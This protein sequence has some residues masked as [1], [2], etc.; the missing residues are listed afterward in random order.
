MNVI[1]KKSLRDLLLSKKADVAG[2]IPNRTIDEF[3]TYLEEQAE[4]IAE[5]AMKGNYYRLH[6]IDI[7]RGIDKWANQKLRGKLHIEVT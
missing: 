1:R 4:T 5:E 7:R 6:P 2:Q 3:A